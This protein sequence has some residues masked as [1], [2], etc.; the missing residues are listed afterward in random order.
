MMISASVFC[1]NMEKI[2]IKT[3][4]LDSMILESVKCDSLRVAYN[5]KSFLLDNLV[6]QNIYIFSQ[7]EESSKIQEN[8]VELNK[9]LQKQKTGVKKKNNKGIYIGAGILAGIIT[10]VIIS[11]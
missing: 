1:Q 4:T 6:D 2:T 11:K 7:L 3:S 5:Q 10:G 8:L 9:I